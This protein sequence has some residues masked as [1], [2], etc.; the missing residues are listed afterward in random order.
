MFLHSLNEEIAQQLGLKYFSP[1]IEAFRK[2]IFNETW[3]DFIEEAPKGACFGPI[4]GGEAPPLFPKDIDEYSIVLHL[5]DPRD[6]MTSQYFSEA[7]SH[8][9]REDGF[10]PTDEK[11]AKWIEEGIDNHVIKYLNWYKQKHKDL[12]EN[13]LGKPNVT[14]L[15]YEDMVLNYK[16]WL[17][18]YLS[19]FE[20]AAH[21]RKFRLSFN[22]KPTISDL[23]GQLYEK[24][25][26]SFKVKEEDIY[27]SKRQVQPGDHKR[28]L[29]QE[30]IETLN[31]EMKDILDAL[32]YS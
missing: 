27:K 3:K 12:I 2:L 19:A 20:H 21:G 14:F 17:K 25:K 18:G 31:N 29:K 8:P 9:R 7:Y 22:K 30:T 6:A 26:N 1:N 4:R 23:Y 15:K 10:N 32:G 16:D 24:H 11:R 28:K 13:L 5:R